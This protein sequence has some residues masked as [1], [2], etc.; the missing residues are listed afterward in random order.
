MPSP[1]HDEI[2]CSQ[3]MTYTIPIQTDDS[4]AW[5]TTSISICP[6]PKDWFQPWFTQAQVPDHLRP[7]NA[8]DAMLCVACIHRFLA[9]DEQLCDCQYVSSGVFQPVCTS[10]QSH[11]TICIQSCVDGGIAEEAIFPPGLDAAGDIDIWTFDPISCAQA[12]GLHGYV[13]G[14][15]LCRMIPV[16]CY[17]E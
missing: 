12:Q 4:A 11:K 2:P 15:K 3:M 6:R 17:Y 13:P 14:C 1:S 10:C 5:S 9:H 7:A 16:S 8:D